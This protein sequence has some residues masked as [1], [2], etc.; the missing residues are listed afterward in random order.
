MIKSALN[1]G[2]VRIGTSTLTKKG[3]KEFDFV[4]VGEF[5]VECADLCIDI[6][7]VSGKSSILISRK[8]LQKTVI[9]KKR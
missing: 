8:Q 5:I 7:K 6:Q 3:L 1:P 4:K 2:G 9:L